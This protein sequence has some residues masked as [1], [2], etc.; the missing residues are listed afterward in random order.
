MVRGRLAFVGAVWLVA[1]SSSG[2]GAGET[3]TDTDGSTGTTTT[4][5]D[6]SS[7][8]GSADTTGGPGGGLEPC[9]P[10]QDGACAQ[11][12][13]A[14][15]PSSGFYCRAECS[16]M[17]EEG[18]ACGSDGV[19][20]P[21]QPGDDALACFSLHDC[22]FTT[23]EGCDLAAGLSCVVVDLSPL[24]T[25]CVPSGDEVMGMAC[26]PWGMHA[27]D[28]GTACLGSDLEGDDP[29][30]CTLWCVPGDPLPAG[31]PACIPFGDEIGSCA[32]CSVVANDCPDG[33]QCHPVNEA[34]GGVCTDYGPG[35]EGDPCI[36]FDSAQS[37]QEG[38]L[39][40]ETD[41]DDVFECV[42]T[43][44][45]AAPMCEDPE[46]SCIDVGVLVGGV[47]TG[48]L[49]FCIDAGVVYCTPGQEP[50]G[51]VQDELCIEIEPGVGI[52]GD[53]CDPTEGEAACAGNQACLPEYEAQFDV[54]PFLAG[55]GACGSGCATDAECGGGTCLLVDGLDAEGVCG[56]TCDPANPACAMG[57]ACVP[58][59][60]DPQVGA[61]I[62]GGGAACDPAMPDSCVGQAETACVALDG[63]SEG[64]CMTACFVQDPMACGDM[65]ALCRE[66]TDPRWHGGFCFGQEPPCDPLLQDCGLGRTCDIVGGEAVGGQA[67]LCEEAGGLMEGGDCSQD[68]TACGA[69]LACV[70]GVCTSYCDPQNDDCAV[71]TCTDISAQFYLPADS[72]GACL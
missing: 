7:T 48:E 23:G 1:C 3:D 9:D 56:T 40:I 21:V 41:A 43:C 19:C 51:C 12:V 36:P 71:G 72:V 18:T 24:R 6:G 47:A 30:V 34:L 33:S 27:C 16:G 38:L 14:G 49:G 44:D 66:K 60:A 50:S 62:D 11:G 13:C 63:G 35:G 70:A 67:F 37:C 8:G 65:A 39:C 69:G 22:D 15:T 17:A 45:P 10:R 55:N 54:V 64:V 25:A 52:C 29:G 58:T 68:D 53:G 4:G 20:L 46:K 2:G 57:Q 42:A 28:V 26:E 5:V 32:E 61:C 59:P 31:C